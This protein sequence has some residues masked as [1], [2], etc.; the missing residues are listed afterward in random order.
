[1]ILFFLLH[2]NGLCPSFLFLLRNLHPRLSDITCLVSVHIYEECVNH[3]IIPMKDYDS[4]IQR[5]PEAQ[6]IKDTSRINMFPKS[7]FHVH[8]YP[9]TH[10]RLIFVSTKNIIDGLYLHM[11]SLR[12]EIV[13]VDLIPLLDSLGSSGCFGTT[14]KTRF[15]VYDFTR[16]LSIYLFSTSLILVL[17]SLPLPL[18]STVTFGLFAITMFLPLL[19]EATS[20]SSF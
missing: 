15:H 6:S 18:P 5:P 8:F 1:M 20:Y 11:R 12:W 4:H 3:V 10:F 2:T 17:V 9:I 19:R 16:T 13:R 7:H 14:T